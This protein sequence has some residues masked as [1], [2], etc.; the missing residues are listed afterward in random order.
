MIEKIIYTLVLL[1]S[2]NLAFAQEKPQRIEI[3]KEFS[4]ASIQ[5]VDIVSSKRNIIVKKGTEN[6]INIQLSFD[7]KADNIENVDWLE[8]LRIKVDSIRKGVVEVYAP[9]VA[10]LAKN[11]IKGE[12]HNLKLDADLIKNA[13]ERQGN[14][15]D[16]V[17][18]RKSELLRQISAQGIRFTIV[19]S[20]PEG[21]SLNVYN[22]YSDVIIESEHKDVTFV[23]KSTNLNAGNIDNLK[24]IAELSTVNIGNCKN[25]RID[26]KNGT[27]SAEEIANLEIKAVT[28]SIDYN[29]GNYAYIES[30]GDKFSIDS[31]GEADVF[32]NFGFLHIDN[33]TRGIKL[34]G[35]NA[36]LKIGKLGSVLK[37][38]VVNDVAARIQIPARYLDGYTVRFEGE[39]STFFAPFE[40][41]EMVEKG[42]VLNTVPETFTPTRFTAQ[43]GKASAKIDIK[44]SNCSI[45]FN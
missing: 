9:G 6:K 26:F 45:V 18:K 5:T 11:W 1:G 25:A 30:E 22:A 31:L 37:H 39:N 20:V 17:L 36:D 4:F 43:V 12:R 2:V 42:K 24:L 3:N 10:G 35:K 19:V 40:K 41:K 13:R 21:I 28:S 23:I 32:K 44:C 34:K 38:I 27:L 7:I 16:P 8:L 29:G 15:N 14:P 33:L